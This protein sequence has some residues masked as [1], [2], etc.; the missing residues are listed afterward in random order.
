[1]DSGKKKQTIKILLG[2]VELKNKAEDMENKAKEMKHTKEKE[3]T[4]PPKNEEAVETAE[5]EA[6]N[7][8]DDIELLRL[9]IKELET[10]ISETQEKYMRALAEIENVRRRM[11]KEKEDAEKFGAF[12]LAKDLILFVDN[13]ERALKCRPD[14][15]QK[16]VAQFVDGISLI[17]KN[18]L[19]ALEKH[20]VK[21]INSDNQPFDPELHQAVSESSIDGVSPGIVVETLQCG[22]TM[23]ERL[24]RAAM[25]SV[26]R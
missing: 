24:L 20:G 25:V 15:S 22:Y 3:R 13:L 7:V 16:E 10:A 11:I 1:M 14:F 4:V 17:L 5:K 26:S 8:D 9:K 19:S 18:V 21:K 6:G 23:N 2:G 12:Y